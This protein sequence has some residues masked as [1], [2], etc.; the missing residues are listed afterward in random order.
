VSVRTQ[1]KKLRVLVV[2][3][4]HGYPIKPFREIFAGYPDMDCTFIDEKVG[5]EAFENVGDWPYDTIVLYNYMKTPSEKQRK[6]FLSLL[7]RGVGLMILHHAIYGY[8][9]WTEFQKIVG[10]TSWLSGAKE[11]F[12]FKIHIED[13]QHPI[14]RRLADF[15]IHDEVYQGH[16]LDPKVHVL[17]TTDE[18][19]NVKAVAW[20]HTYR[21][22][23]VCYL[24]LGHDDK[25]YSHPQFR[26]VLGRAIRWTAGRL[27]MSEASGQS[28]Q[29]SIRVACIGNSI[30]AG[31]GAASGESY[32]DQLGRMLGGKWKV[33]NFGV[34]G[35][36]LLNHGDKPYQKERAFHAA[37]QYQPQV[38]I[39]MLG[40]NDTK[41]QNWKFQD[42]FAAD[43]KDLV[44]QFARLPSKPRIF[45]CRPVP[46]P[47]SGNFGI[48]EAGVQ[49]EIP[50]IDK[51]AEEMKVGE[52]DMH[53][54]L[55]DHPE[56]L[57]DRVHP[58][59]AGAALMAKAAFQALTGQAF[60]GKVPAAAPKAKAA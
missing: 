49:A 16:R 10:V 9:P 25:A 36:T 19:A 45:I 60:K 42:E 47:G 24:Q 17:L 52:I 48:N 51:I 39:I 2:T 54:A 32:P 44:G 57:P 35:S 59:T 23:P 7:D 56:M 55:K 46:V 5:G 29:G 1:A 33:R 41:P 34:S 37:L 14:T 12:Q 40:T 3:G 11:G 4:G 28:N 50:M 27:P 18:P 30:T 15:T 21:K 13:P 31:V 58:N 26:E 8:R 22:S 20:V 53:A 6:N 38:V 43:Y